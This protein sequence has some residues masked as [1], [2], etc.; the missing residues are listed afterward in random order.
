MLSKDMEA[1]FNEQV[2]SELYSAYLYL[3][4][5]A[6][7]ETLNLNGFAHWM[8]IQF[9]EEQMH[10]LKI[11]DFISERG[12]RVHLQA[13][14]EPPVEWDS[15]LKVFEHTMEHEQDVTQKINKLV[16]LAIKGSDHASNNFLQW[17]VSEQVE[18]EASVDAVLQQL[19][20]VGDAGHAL[21]MIDRE[22]V[23]RTLPPAEPDAG[24]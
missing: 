13:I 15:P 22:L 16:D 23:T 12:G 20:L 6:Y 4:M 14:A 19:R 1:A 24:A 9:Q 5:A 10:A 3:A 21:F 18:E 8:K 2:N 7:F 11:V 17:F